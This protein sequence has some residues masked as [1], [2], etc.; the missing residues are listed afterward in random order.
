ME[1]STRHARQC[2]GPGAIGDSD[3]ASRPAMPTKDREESPLMASVAIVFPLLP[4][5]ADEA[6]QF[7]QQLTGPR[8]DEFNAAEARFGFTRQSWYLQPTPAGVQLIAYLE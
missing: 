7:A 8:R 4:G 6:K 1:Q 3:R 2:D 5:K